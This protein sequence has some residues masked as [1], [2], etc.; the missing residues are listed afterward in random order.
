MTKTLRIKVTGK[1]QGV[2]YRKFTKEKADILNIK[3]TVKNL[4]DGSVEVYA[5]SDLLNLEKFVSFLKKGPIFA[6]V[7]G[8][9]Y[10]EVPSES[11]DGFNILK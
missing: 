1:V 11:F 7:D 2:Y 10:E 3:G 8:L 4:T 6:R 5:N 9:E